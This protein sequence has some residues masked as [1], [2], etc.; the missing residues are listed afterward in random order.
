MKKSVDFPHH[1]PDIRAA[2]NVTL[3]EHQEDVRILA[4]LEDKLQCAALRIYEP[5]P[6]QDRF[7]RCDVKEALIR[8]GNQTGGS[9]ALFV[10]VARAAM[11]CD[12]YDKYPKRPLVITCLGYGEKHIGKV[13]H[14]YLFRVGAFQMI[15]DLET[16]QWR[17][18]RPWQDKG[19]EAEVKPAP[20][21]IPPHAL[22]PFSWEKKAER[23]FSIAFLKNGTEIYALN[24]QGDSSHAQGFQIDLAAIDEDMATDG[25]YDEQ[26]FRASMRN[27]KM[28]WAAIPHA[29]T[30]DM[31][32]MLQ[33]AEDES[34]N[35]D[36]QTVLFTATAFD[37]PYMPDEARKQN[38]RIA[39]SQGEDVYRQRILGELTEESTLMYPTFNKRLHAALP[40]KDDR[41]HAVHQI[42]RECGG[43][44]PT[45]WCRY[46]VVDPGHTVCAV[47]FWAVSPESVGDFKVCYDELYLR[48]CDR[49][50]F[51][52]GMQEKCHDR[53]FQ[54]FI[55]DAHGGNLR[56]LGS[57]ILPR[58]Q[59]EAELKDRR[60]TCVE[61]D[62]YFING[63]DDI[64]GRVECLRG[65]LRIQEHGWPKMLV[66]VEH[67][68]NLVREIQRF[69]KKTVKIGGA[70]MVID[71]GN[72]RMPCHATETAEYAAAHGLPY[73]KPSH[74]PSKESFVQRMIR[75]RE[76][77]AKQREAK[78]GPERQNYINLGA[79]GVPVS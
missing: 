58:Y 44:P 12:P 24:T 40:D 3:R 47:T 69:K 78:Y 67:C 57:G 33:R 42:L 72:R 18:F 31:M 49:V 63:S 8:K 60:I 1:D 15:R 55:I 19:R 20:P 23:V 21:L 59:Y 10:E 76:L 52:A 51:G 17:T 48:Q 34:D 73:I 13:I 56:E 16:G 53:V 39:R 11:W 54:A 29:K 74:K 2:D 50:K 68:P 27:G 46:A 9:L 38:I 70:D 22:K 7:H 25:W 71:E 36:P 4:H 32:N 64:K 77:R 66:N 79:R 26:L 75:E 65:W 37:N 30:E 14:K 62:H 45:D 6:Y 35:E 43:D 61:T 28:R 5:L 41:L